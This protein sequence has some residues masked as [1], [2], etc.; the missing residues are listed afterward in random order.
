MNRKDFIK[1]TGWSI[2]LGSILI[3]SGYLLLRP[4]TDKKCHLD[5]ICK[6]CKKL[7]ICSLP[8]AKDHKNNKSNNR[9]D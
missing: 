2:L 3:G 4:K 7:N 8:K 9:L 6:N 1:K 5:F